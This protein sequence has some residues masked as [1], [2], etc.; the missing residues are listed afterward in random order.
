MEREPRAS[1]P[2]RANVRPI[3]TVLAAVL[4]LAACAGGPGASGSGTSP[5]LDGDWVLVAGAGRD[6]AIPLVDG[7]DITLSIGG[8]TVSGRAACNQYGGTVTVSGTAIRFSDMAS[9]EM[10]CAEPVMASE[11]AYWAALGAV[12]RVAL[13][14][15][16][17]ILAGNGVQL[18]FARVPPVADASLTGTQWRLE[19][20]ISGDAASSVQ[21]EP[22]L[23]LR[24]DGRLEATTGCSVVSGRYAVDGEELRVTSLEVQAP[25]ACDAAMSG[26]HQ[27]IVSVLSETATFRIEGAALTLMR[28][29]D[30]LGYRSG[31]SGTG[32]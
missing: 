30:G 27:L 32:G 22:T 11:A 13:E 31:Q 4:L 14:D 6:G 25:A 24:D 17:L 29:A 23:L 26:Q 9:T 20:L 16:R 10:A 5:S 2:R 8:T 7:A 1:G 12:E 28:G 15:E 19:T 21:G 3:V 18:Q